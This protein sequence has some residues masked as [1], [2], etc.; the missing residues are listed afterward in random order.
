MMRVLLK[1]LLVAATAAGSLGMVACSAYA[2]SY[3]VSACSPTSSSGL[4]AHTNTFT[5]A[6]AAGNNCRGP[7]IGP[8][9][10]SNEGALYG[11]DILGASA[12]SIP[13]AARAGWTLAAPTGTT[14][15]AISYYRSLSSFTTSDLISGLFQAD[16]SPLEQ[17][18]IPWPFPSGSSIVC[19]KVND[20]APVTFNGL[21]T[22]SLF[23]GVMCQ[24]VTN[25]TGCT[26]GG[27]IHA[28][29]A[30]LYSARVTLSE[31]GAPTLGNVAGSLWAGGVVSGTVP[32]TFAAS[33]ASGIRE[34]AVRS[35]SGQTLVSALQS[36]DFGSVPPC[37]QQPAGSLSVDTTRVSDGPHTFSLVVTDA[38]G[39]T[40]VATSPTVV[41]NN[42]GP[43]APA[44]LTATAKGG[45]SNVVALAWRNPVGAPAPITAGRVQLCQST[46][47]A[48]VAVGA[49]GAAQVT[50]PGP[51]LYTVRLWL[52]DSQ[53]RGGPHNAALTSVTVPSGD[54]A[55]SSGAT[56]TRVTAVLNGRRLRVA[57]TIARTGRVRVSWRS[58]SRGG[59]TLG[60][61][62][63][64]VSIRSHKIALTF[65]PATRARRGTIRIAVRS[66]KRVVAQARA[67]R[68]IS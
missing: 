39:N 15:T 35:D 47:P 53:G 63:R 66:G 48:A 50:A 32:V 38:A 60:S 55:G 12:A 30:R 22:T 40:Q 11:E 2:G 43:P 7:A 56:R 4:W 41:V 58:K 17:C 65:M 21:S 62:S 52:L 13:N 26:A 57:G 24:I 25:A 61:G 19:E 6:L 20:Q 51:G 31:S 8:T 33:D 54:A 64:T 5:A 1:L 67:R 44:A 3:V 10:G 45:G 18:K 34:Q 23:L 68:T 46:C 59:R 29:T 49:S 36:C 14:I 28:A 42:G 16:G 9:N 37:P 27:T